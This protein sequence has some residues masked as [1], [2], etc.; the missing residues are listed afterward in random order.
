MR[1][2]PVQSNPLQQ[3]TQKSLARILPRL[4]AQ[5]ASETGTAEWR[6]FRARL[7][8]NF[9]NLFRLLLRLYGGQ[10]DFFYH[11]ESILAMAA[12]MW[13]ARPPE[14]KALDAQREADPL[15]FQSE[16]MLGG[17]CYVDL[18]AGD[19]KGIREKIPYF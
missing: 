14:L 2:S 17:V 4:E 15:W 3:Q 18:F 7:E 9:P 16:K 19:L 12:R 13:L 1:A 5:F 6:A 11:L 8:A 10:Y